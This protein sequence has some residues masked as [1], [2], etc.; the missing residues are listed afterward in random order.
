MLL[1]PWPE[2]GY[3]QAR[4]RAE[5]RA[6]AGAMVEVLRGRLGDERIRGIY[7]KGSAHKPWDSAID[8]VP[9]VSDVDVHLW[10]HSSE[11]LDD[12]R[13][14][15]AA[16]ETADAILGAFRRRVGQPLHVPKP[17]LSIV[18]TLR[19]LPG[20]VESPAATVETLFGE[21]Y[22]AADPS[23]EQAASVRDRDRESLRQHDE[24]LAALGLRAIDRPGPYLR[25]IFDELPWR[26]SPVAPRVL[27]ASGGG[28]DEVWSANRTRLVAM[29]E[30]RGFDAL[31]RAYVSYYE[32]AWRLLRDE[33]AALRDAVQAGVAVIRLGGELAGG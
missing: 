13:D 11:D 3:P 26:V 2:A 4:L 1:E 24:F 8:Y 30:S 12:L 17:Q 21:P 10:L 28:Y 14:L 15:D 25:R 31:A 29:L 32:A 6:L 7:L 23:A 5:V 19:D 20:Y 18:N 9:T 16:L 33:D 27:S 22:R